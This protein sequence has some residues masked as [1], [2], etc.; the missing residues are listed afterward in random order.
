MAR[1]VAYKFLLQQGFSNDTEDTAPLHVRG[2]QFQPILVGTTMAY[3]IW[4]QSAPL[5][6]VV[7]GILWLNTLLP[8]LNPFEN[9]YNLLFA[10]N[11]KERHLEPAPGPRRFAQGMAAAFMMI[12]GYAITQGWWT[13]VY[14]FEGFI[15]LAFLVLLGF[16][17]CLGAYIFQM[18]KGNVQFA[19]ATCPWSR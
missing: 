14:V 8:R 13:T 3:A 11:S 19:N 2:L 9:L 16:R 17:F 18:L 6:L 5:F 7:A 15:A 4:I 10:R 1:S 12:A